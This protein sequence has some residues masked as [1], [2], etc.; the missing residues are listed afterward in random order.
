MVL[1][2]GA[3]ALGAKVLLLLLW[4]G[5]AMVRVSNAAAVKAVTTKFKIT[6]A[7]HAS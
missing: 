7:I 6:V 3:Q 4:P 1:L 5:F 2:S